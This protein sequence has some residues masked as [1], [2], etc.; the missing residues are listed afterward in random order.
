MVVR[1]HVGDPQVPGVAIGAAAAA[2]L[3]A[4]GDA[5]QRCA[6]AH[7]KLA[8]ERELVRGDVPRLDALDVARHALSDGA[9]PQ[10]PVHDRE[11][12]LVLG[13]RL[14]EPRLLVEHRALEHVG[15]LI[16]GARAVFKPRA[17]AQ[18]Q[19]ARRDMLI[20]RL[21]AALQVDAEDPQPVA[22]G[23]VAIEHPGADRPRS[24]PRRR[25]RSRTARTPSRRPGGRRWRAP[26]RAARRRRSAPRRAAR[27][28]GDRA[29]HSPS[30]EV[31]TAALSS[32]ARRTSRGR[33]AWRCRTRETREAGAASRNL[34]RARWSCESEQAGE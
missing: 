33:P 2:R 22:L 30:I 10:R 19:R 20:A 17:E 28:R 7:R 3:A 12:A 14:G 34:A 13:E 27:P 21:A 15:Q 26:P 24:A 18:P 25:R 32:R 29:R 5:E 11:R 4:A 8:E 31:S 23:S 16:R 1:P 9:Q 6:L